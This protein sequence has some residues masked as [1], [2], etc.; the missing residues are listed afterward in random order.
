[1]IPPK[2]VKKNDL[3]AIGK[4]LQLILGN[5][6]SVMAR[7]TDDVNQF[8]KLLRAA[9]IYQDLIDYYR[10]ERKIDEIEFRE[11]CEKALKE[12]RL[13]RNAA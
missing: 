1:M 9:G 5:L 4:N 6:L 12:R 3:S 10:V 11:K 13:L 7:K 2:R 8:F